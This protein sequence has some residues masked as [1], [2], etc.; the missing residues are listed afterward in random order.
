MPEMPGYERWKCLPHGRFIDAGPARANT[1]S[2]PGHSV[3]FPAFTGIRVPLTATITA[4]DASSAGGSPYHWPFR[5]RAR[6]SPVLLGTA[7]VVRRRSHRWPG[8][9]VGAAGPV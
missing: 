8:G 1:R 3:G 5:G 6:R 9:L 7:P 2:R 4:V